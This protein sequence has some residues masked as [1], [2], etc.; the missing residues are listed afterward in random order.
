M[1]FNPK[2]EMSISIKKA[3]N[4]ALKI[5]KYSFIIFTF[6]YWIGVIIDDWIFIKKYWNTNWEEYIQIWVLYF[7]AISM[8]L[9]FYFWIVSS[10]IIL[11]Y[12]KIIKPLKEKKRARKN[13]VHLVDN[14]KNKTEK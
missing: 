1:K 14:T 12:H 11:V 6:V 8:A 13:R 9:S 7:I 4:K 10:I 3:F 2:L 5:F